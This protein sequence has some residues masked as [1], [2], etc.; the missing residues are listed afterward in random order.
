MLDP[1]LVHWLIGLTTAGVVALLTALALG[2][3][4]GITRLPLGG[5]YV[6][7]AGD[8]DNYEDRDGI[9][10]E[11]SIRAFSDTRPRVA[12]WLAALL[13]LGSSVAAGVLVL[14]DAAHEHAPVL[15]ELAAW[16]EPACWVRRDGT[17]SFCHVYLLYLD[18]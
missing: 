15:S 14:K 4:W 5:G 3:A 8:D 9:A 13:G 12:V 11:H 17:H 16:A 1:D 2:Y 6:Q 10:T 18:R 7:L